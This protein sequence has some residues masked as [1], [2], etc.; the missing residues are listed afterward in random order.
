MS[1][2]G[3]P[4]DSSPGRLT[5]LG[6]YELMSSIGRGG[7]GEVYRGRDTRLNR[8]VAVKVLPPDM[9]HSAEARRRFQREAQAIAALNHRHV[10]AVHDVG[11]DDGVDFL[12]MEYVD[13]E[14]LASRLRRGPMPL[15]EVLARGIEIL[16]ALAHAHESGIVHRDLKPSNI[17]LT[18]SGAKLLDF[19]I[20]ALRRDL[21]NVDSVSDT[22]ATAR[23]QVFARCSTWRRS[24]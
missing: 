24:S 17:M 10:C 16:D 2:P 7:M 11:H 8:T 5:R 23:G 22:S 15:D 18:K 4:D 20:A 9:A 21:R 19:G 1:G 3:A 14:S 6:P 12:V 13:G